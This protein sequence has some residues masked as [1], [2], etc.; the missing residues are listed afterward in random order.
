MKI[1]QVQDQEKD[2]YVLFVYQEKP[3][4]PVLHLVFPAFPEEIWTNYV[5]V[6]VEI[7]CSVLAR[8]CFFFL[9]F[10]D[11]S[12]Q[13]TVAIVN[14]GDAMETCHVTRLEMG[15]MTSLNETTSKRDLFQF[16]YT[17]K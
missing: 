5:P 12:S 9:R 14:H 11:V 6:C 4:S 15:S 17:T 16:R 1:D 8:C 2:T 13:Q 10:V 3:Q 7:R